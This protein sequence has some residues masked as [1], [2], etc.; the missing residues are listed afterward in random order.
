MHISLATQLDRGFRGRILLAVAP[1][2]GRVKLLRDFCLATAHDPNLV[3]NVDGS[4]L[5]LILDLASH[6]A[7]DTTH[8]T[9]LAEEESSVLRGQRICAASVWTSRPRLAFGVAGVRGRERKRARRRSLVL[10][11][12]LFLRRRIRIPFQPILT[13]GLRYVGGVI[14]IS[15]YTTP[16]THPVLDRAEHHPLRHSHC[17]PFHSADVRGVAVAPRFTENSSGN[18][19]SRVLFT[20]MATE[21]KGAA[22][23]E[24]RRRPPPSMSCRSSRTSCDISARKLIKYIADNLI[25]PAWTSILDLAPCMSAGG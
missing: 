3:V 5:A 22:H 7:A 21:R 1:G 4:G 20:P 10:A 8:K 19:R 23:V 25:I 6:T 11:T 12:F 13:S 9:R 2:N 14:L 17:R 18:D 16:A 15:V 24:F